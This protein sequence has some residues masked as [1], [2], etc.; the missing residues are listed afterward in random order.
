MLNLKQQ[1][2]L[3]GFDNN[4][5]L[6]ALISQLITT[7]GEQHDIITTLQEENEITKTPYTKPIAQI[8][9]VFV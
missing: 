3:T 8:R 9:A 6:K 2:N 1:L 4:T 5:A 7:V